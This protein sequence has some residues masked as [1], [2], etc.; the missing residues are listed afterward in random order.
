MPDVVTRVLSAIVAR[1][2]AGDRSNGASIRAPVL[3]AHTAPAGGG[4][5]GVTGASPGRLDKVWTDSPGAGNHTSS[6]GA[7][8]HR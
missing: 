5:A 1:N 3:F 7:E 6:T 2:V 8:V 4:G